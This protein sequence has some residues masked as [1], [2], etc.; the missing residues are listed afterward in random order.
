MTENHILLIIRIFY[1]ELASNI[2]V[3]SCSGKLS[4]NKNKI[5]EILEDETLMIQKEYNQISKT[6]NLKFNEIEKLVC[7]DD[8]LENEIL[9]DEY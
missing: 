2:F 8:C 6:E 9:T 1:P 4:F 3:N 7:T 5:H